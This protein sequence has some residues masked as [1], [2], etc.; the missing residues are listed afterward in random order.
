M[1]SRRLLSALLLIVAA[2]E[3]PPR[4][5]AI[6][7]PA[8]IA[9]HQIALKRRLLA[10]RLIVSAAATIE[11]VLIDIRRRVIVTAGVFT[12]EAALQARLPMIW[13]GTDD[14]LR[15]HYTVLKDTV[16]KGDIEA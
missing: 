15:P 8:A 6:V 14:E 5:L 4:Y 16:L 3:D 10:P 9:S 1:C 11:L 13:F 2:A 7:R 12:G